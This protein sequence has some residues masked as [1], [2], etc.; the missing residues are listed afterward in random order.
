MFG[1]MQLIPYLKLST[2]HSDGK[3]L[4]KWVKYQNMDN[5]EQF[6]QWDERHL[7]I[8]EHSTSHLEN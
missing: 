7:A 3:R 1:I 6:Y 4:R 8:G 5:M 2:L